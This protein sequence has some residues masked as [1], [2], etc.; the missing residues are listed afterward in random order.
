LNPETNTG[1]IEKIKHAPERYDLQLP[2]AFK[3][4]KNGEVL[5]SLQSD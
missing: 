2:D 5:V 1:H 4:I 3:N